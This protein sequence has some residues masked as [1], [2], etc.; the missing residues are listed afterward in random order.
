MGAAWYLFTTTIFKISFVVSVIQL[1][2]CKLPANIN[3]LVISCPS[4]ASIT[5]IKPFLLGYSFSGQA[6]AAASIFL[7]SKLLIGF[8]STLF[9]FEIPLCATNSPFI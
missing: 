4:S 9:M 2:F 5:G 8:V 6:N 7:Q 1:P 3:L